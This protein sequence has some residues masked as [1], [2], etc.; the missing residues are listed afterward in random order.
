[1]RL[2]IAGATGNV[3]REIIRLLEESA[4]LHLGVKPVFLSSSVSE[5]EEIPFGDDEISVKSLKDYTFGQIDVIVF[6]TPAEVSKV[7]IPQALEKNVQVID[8]SGA[9]RTDEGTPMIVDAVN[10]ALVTKETP[11][12][13]IP[14]VATVQLATVI[15]PLLK[16]AELKRVDSTCMYP[17]SRAGKM[18]MDE[19]FAQSAGLLGGAGSGDEMEGQEF[20]AQV[21]FNVI[22]QVGDFTGAN[23]EAETALLLE[24]N[25]VLKTPTPVL[26]TAVYVPT[27]VG[28]SQSV[29][30]DFNGVITAGDVRDILGKIEGVSVIDAPEKCEYS[31]PYG[32]AETSHIFVSRVRDNPLTPGA[33][34]LWLTCDNLRTGAAL[35][36]VKVLERLL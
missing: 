36:V 35:Q 24:L 17:T 29:T 11:Q 8:L 14:D 32:T 34:K 16:K 19:L 28:M 5:G 9:Y 20:K 27:F 26:S 33:I 23:T 2:A 1:M 22:P 31:T 25:R 3:G 4:T 12:I 21:A 10:G 6:A 13:S 18:A 30:L 15:A 7:Y